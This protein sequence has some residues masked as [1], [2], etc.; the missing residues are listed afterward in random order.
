VI[1]QFEATILTAD[2]LNSS[3]LADSLIVLLMFSFLWGFG[4]IGILICFLQKRIQKDK[5]KNFADEK[6]KAVSRRRGSTTDIN[7]ILAKYLDEVFPVVYQ[8][9]SYFTRLVH[10]VLKHHR[11]IELITT[12]SQGVDM[13]KI[14]TCVHL[15]TVQTMLMFLLAVCYELQVSAAFLFCL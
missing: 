6:I 10:E 7:L 5:I 11:Y 12:R 15:L 1:T 14:I 3:S 4:L 13:R 8:T 9:Q 2:D